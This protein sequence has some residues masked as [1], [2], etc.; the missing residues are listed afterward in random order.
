MN[1]M[2]SLSICNGSIN[3]YVITFVGLHLLL[4]IYVLSYFVILF[5][6]FILLIKKNDSN[7]EYMKHDV[8]IFFACFISFIILRVIDSLIAFYQIKNIGD[9]TKIS[10][11]I[12]YFNIISECFFNLFILYYLSKILAH[13]ESYVNK[14]FGI[15]SVEGSS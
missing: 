9:T 13:K 4:D 7:F 8:Y 1:Q 11:R 5:V 14:S 6:V 3:A 2:I 10:D 15:Y 12:S